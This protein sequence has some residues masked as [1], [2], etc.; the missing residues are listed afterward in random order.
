SKVPKLIHHC[1]L[2][3]FEKKK[4]RRNIIT[5]PKPPCISK[6]PK[7]IYHCLLNNFEK[8]KCRRNIITNPKPPTLYVGLSMVKPLQYLARNSLAKGASR[9]TADISLLSRA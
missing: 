5:N 1:L 9:K 4:C 2:N 7:L 6:V 8:K 3:N